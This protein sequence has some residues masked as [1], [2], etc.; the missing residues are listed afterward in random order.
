MAIYENLKVKDQFIVGH[1]LREPFDVL[2]SI[3]AQTTEEEPGEES[4]EKPQGRAYRRVVALP[5]TWGGAD[6]LTALRAFQGD[7]GGTVD[8][9]T[10]ADLDSADLLRWSLSDHGSLKGLMVEAAGVEP[11]SEAEF[12]GTSTSVSGI[13]ISPRGSSRRDPVRPAAV[14][15]P[16]R[17]RGAPGQAS[18]RL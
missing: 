10:W 11:A 16:G 6:D 7:S 4:D 8:G 9:A 1:E 17:G 14:I 18:R 2:L 15:V 12:L 13:L 5:A 3:R